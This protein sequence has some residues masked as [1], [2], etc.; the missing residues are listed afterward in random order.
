LVEPPY[1]NVGGENTDK[2][3]DKCPN[4]LGIYMISP[5]KNVQHYTDVGEY[6]DFKNVQIR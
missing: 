3:L 6:D 1:K 5:F 4:P 2:L